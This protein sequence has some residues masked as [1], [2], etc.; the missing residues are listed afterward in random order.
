MKWYNRLQIQ[1]QLDFRLT[2][3][4]KTVREWALNVESR[5]HWKGKVIYDTKPQFP[6]EK[7][8]WFSV[9]VRLLGLDVGFGVYWGKKP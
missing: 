7:T 3:G 5:L 8:T 9:A 4:N 2:P 6:R 1:V